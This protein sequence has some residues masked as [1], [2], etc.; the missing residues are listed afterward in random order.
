MEKKELIKQYEAGELKVNSVS[1]ISNN[2]GAA[3][4][5][6][7]HGIED[8]VFGFVSS[9]DKKSYFFVKLQYLT[10]KIKFK[11]GQLSFDLDSFIR[12]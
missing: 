6:I 3:I 11:V 8:K 2:A 1:S 9:G 5:H 12:V 7:E 4:V 10:D